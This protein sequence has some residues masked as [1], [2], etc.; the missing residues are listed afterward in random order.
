MKIKGKTI[1]APKP[2]LCVIERDD[3]QFVF[4]LQAVLDYTDFDAVCP[5]PEPPKV[6]RP[7]GDVTENITSPVYLK[8]LEEYGT[9][10]TYWLIIKS[11]E[12]TEGLEWEKVNLGDPDTWEL[13][14]DELTDCG[15]T[16]GEIVYLIN[17]IYNVNSLDEE[18]MKEA[19]DRFTH[20]Q[21]EEQV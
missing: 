1:G 14:K 13:Y 19:L 18:R 6:L 11:L 2:R 17:Q 9:Q 5:K 21:S 16:E 15:L 20:S 3:E 4:T 10:K 8:T 7:G 12:A